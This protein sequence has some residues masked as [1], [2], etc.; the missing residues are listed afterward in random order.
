MGQNIVRFQLVHEIETFKPPPLEELRPKIFE[1]YVEEKDG[2]N[3]RRVFSFSLVFITRLTSILY[4]A[5]YP[6]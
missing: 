5:F 3:L 6:R 2:Y 1:Q 4:V